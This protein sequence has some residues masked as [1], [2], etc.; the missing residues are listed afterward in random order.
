M[1]ISA[2]LCVVLRTR[3]SEGA[4]SCYRTCPTRRT[5]LPLSDQRKSVN[6]IQYKHGTSGTLPILVPMCCSRLPRTAFLHAVDPA[7][8]PRNVDVLFEHVGL[9]DGSSFVVAQKRGGPRPSQVGGHPSVHRP[10]GSAASARAVFSRMVITIGTSGPC[11]HRS[12]PDGSRSR[13]ATAPGR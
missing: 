11:G 2:P 1:K 5:T 9:A 3:Q 6:V 7:R 8:S 13:A 4:P 10:G 12:P